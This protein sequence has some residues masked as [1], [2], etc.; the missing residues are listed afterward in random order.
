MKHH[1]FII[2]MMGSGNSTIGPLLSDKLQISHV[3]I[4]NDLEKIFNLNIEEIF[5]HYTEEQFRVFESRYFL[6]HIKNSPNVYSTGGGIVL[7]KQNRLVL[8]KNGYTIFL[9]ASI[10]VLYNRI[11]NDANQRPLFKNKNM[12]EKLLNQRIHYY[13]DCANFVIDTDNETPQEIVRQI[14]NQLNH[15]N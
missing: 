6:E 14:I 2:G 1:I 7:N 4:D 15:A 13:R 9:N 11:K 8:K 12:L 10:P 3:D 5:N